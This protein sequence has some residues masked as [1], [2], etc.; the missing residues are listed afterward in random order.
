[1]SIRSKLIITYLSVALIPAVFVGFLT[2]HNYRDSFEAAS[3]ADMNELAAFKADK[4]ETYFTWVKAYLRTTQSFYNIKKTLPALTRLAGL[5][6]D[7]EYLAAKK[8][9]D[10]QLRPLQADLS[11]TDILLISPGG[12][13]V[14]TSS[15]GRPRKDFAEALPGSWKKTLTEGRKELSI[16]EV[17]FD[18]RRKSSPEMLMAAPVTDLS[19]AFGGVAVFELNLAP[20]YRLTEDRTGLHE[21][22]EVL[23][24][25][26]RG[27]R[28][29]YLNPLRHD[30][31]PVLTKSVTLGS[32][33]GIPVQKAARGESG[34]GISR[35]YRGREV[36]AGWRYIPSLGW[37]IVAK[38]DAAEAFSE[39]EKLQRLLL[40]LLAL[41][42]AACCA[43]AI[44][45]GR[46]I[47]EP[48]QKLSAGAEIIGAG[49]LDYKVGGGQADEIGQLGRAFDEMTT[50]LKKTLASRDSL[51]A[52]VRER[53]QAEQERERLLVELRE[54]ES[55]VRLKIESIIAPEGNV[56][57]LELAD[58]LDAGAFQQLLDKFYALERIP[59]GLIDIKGKVLVGVG[60]QDICTKFHRATP[61]SCAYCLESDT[62]L[63]SGVPPGEFRLYKCRNGLWDVATPIMLGGKHKG[64]LFI[65]QFFLK[66]ERPDLEFFRRQAKRYGFDEKEYLAALDRVPRIERGSLDTIMGFFLK[67][68]QMLSQTSFNNLTLARTLTE[69]E[70]LNNS[71]KESEKR[72][73]KAQEMAH[74]G[75]WEL[76]LPGNQLSWSD[77]VYRIFGLEPGEFPATYEAFLEAVHPEDRAAVDAAYAG[78]VR[79]GK[80]SYEI[81]HRVVRRSSGEV[82]YVHERCVHSRDAGGAVV[83]SVGMV[84][85]ITE[86]KKA[87]V[88]L[89]RSNENL[90]QFAYVASHDLQ[91]PLR[92]MSSYSALLARRYKGKLDPDADD[93]IN[94]IVDGA[95]RLQRLINDLLAYS[96]AGR[97]EKAEVGVDCGALLTRVLAGMKVAIDESGA[98]VTS[99]PLPELTG[100]ESSFVQL[101][102]NLVGN[103][104][105]FRGKEAP[106]IHVGAVR[107][108]RNWLFSVKDN[109]IG[110]EA[111][112]K[113]RI[114]LI[115][116]R[117]HGRE[118]YPGTGIGLSICK[119]IVEAAGGKIWLESEPGKGSTFYFTIP[120]KG[121]SGNVK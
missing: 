53:K 29:L 57:N 47:S 103:A 93:F 82:R 23:L 94:Y 99:G 5:P 113:D 55:R 27:G 79:E 115:F 14:Y 102:Q 110:I 101:F 116:Q 52:E 1:M 45:L 33:E 109:G 42:G 36:M 10:D 95:G 97:G 19:G 107:K 2:F 73:N 106:H 85:D 62:Q 68:A 3:I 90:E 48:I 34:S 8:T 40:L 24:G 13:I 35:D 117:L 72:L 100:S 7:A 81:E 96:R 15:G 114:F 54:S 78:S 16:S 50:N 63:T 119:K 88:E 17:A 18:P 61:A 20:V 105:K 83:R 77:E 84:H 75:S 98:A 121:E 21:T 108:G 9:L 58:I 76:D 39:I 28:V 32:L 56:D 74:L 12:K 66:D 89:K 118:E 49:N 59:I 60:W 43:I 46:S 87:E 31:A 6:N 92:M 11:L 120:A 44:S 69:R 70:A 64:N 37:G 111:Q 25:S 65:G 104:I 71:L 91:E 30:P 41:T 4:I 80:D 22:G 112:Y 67:L 38:I 86:R 26:K 51:D